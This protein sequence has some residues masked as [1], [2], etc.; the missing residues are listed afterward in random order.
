MVALCAAGV[1]PRNPWVGLRIPAL[2]AS[3][4]AWSAGHRGAILPV[5]CSAVVNVVLAVL[6]TTVLSEVRGP[7]LVGLVLLVL[8]AGTVMGAFRGARAARAV[9]SR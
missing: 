2:F 7:L 6:A 1:I 4:D 3:D 8:L 5:I 9:E